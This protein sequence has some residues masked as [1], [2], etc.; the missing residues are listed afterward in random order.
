[1]KHKRRNRKPL[2][3]A[4]AKKL[5]TQ[6]LLFTM[7][8]E[9]VIAAR[10]KAAADGQAPI[11]QPGLMYCEMKGTVTIWEAAQDLSVGKSTIFEMLDRGELEYF[12]VGPDGATRNHKRILSSS[13]AAFINRRKNQP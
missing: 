11:A 10:A 3:A 13:V 6:L 2:T 5:G 7:P 9:K 4:Q 12:R 1:M 8:G